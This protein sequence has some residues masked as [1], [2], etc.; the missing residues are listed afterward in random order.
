MLFKYVPSPQHNFAQSYQFII[1]NDDTFLAVNS[2]ATLFT[3]MTSLDSCI[4][5]RDTYLC[6]KNM[7]R[8]AT[9]NNCLFN[10]YMSNEET[11]ETCEFKIEKIR[12]YGIRLNNAKLFYNPANNATFAK[13]ECEDQKDATRIPIHSPSIISLVPGCKLTTKDFIFKWTRELFSKSLNPQL[14][15]TPGSEIFGL[16]NMGSKGSEIKEFVEKMADKPIT[17]KMV[18]IEHK[19]HLHQLSHKTKNMTMAFSSTAGV[20]CIII[21]LLIIFNA[22]RRQGSNQIFKSSVTMSSLLPDNEVGPG[23]LIK[24]TT[25]EAQKEQTSSTSRLY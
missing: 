6:Q 12:T 17:M 15:S 21:V 25:N 16:I 24:G 2:E 13:I 3:T 19:F 11:R 14:V 1:E 9:K 4:S 5:M 8:K 7:I 22:K 20:I 10:L 18:D 23:G